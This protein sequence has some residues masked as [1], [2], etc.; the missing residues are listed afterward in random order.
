MT[1]HLRQL[2]TRNVCAY[3]M[4]LALRHVGRGR[5]DRRQEDVFEVLIEDADAPRPVLRDLARDLVSVA[6]DVDAQQATRTLDLA[7]RRIARE[8]VERRRLVIERRLDDF[9]VRLQLLDLPGQA[10]RSAVHYG[11]A[12]RSA[13]HLAD[14]V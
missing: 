12:F 10:K 3:R 7:D 9:D 1:N 11:D 6:A 14:L 8:A 5:R 13:L 2:T 4:A